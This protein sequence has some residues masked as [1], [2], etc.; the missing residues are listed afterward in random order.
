MRRDRGWVAL[1]SS[2]S[3][4]LQEDCREGQGMPECGSPH[5]FAS[6][7]SA[8]RA[9][10][11]VE[12]PE[13]WQPQ[14]P[15]RLR[16]PRRAAVPLPPPQTPHLCAPH[17][18]RGSTCSADAPTPHQHP[19]PGQAWLPLGVGHSEAGYLQND[20]Y[21]QCSVTQ[22]TVTACARTQAWLPPH[23]PLCGASMD[24]LGSHGLRP[25]Q[26]TP[27]PPSF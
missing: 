2:A 3:T 13:G 20:M 27:T 14:L 26:A 16:R 15:G 6:C 24:Y 25:R 19:E 1:E 22:S 17:P 12:L 23:L 8:S 5:G 10:A 7:T 11:L 18:C 4:W 21:P 9:L